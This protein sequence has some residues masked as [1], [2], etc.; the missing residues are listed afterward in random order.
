VHRMVKAPIMRKGLKA[1]LKKT[2]ASKSGLTDHLSGDPRSSTRT[3]P[4]R[5]DGA[6]SGGCH[7]LPGCFEGLLFARLSLT[8]RSQWFA[9]MAGLGKGWRPGSPVFCA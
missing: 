5:P 7:N 6:R 9:P 3:G 2:V 4:C 1:G 8:D